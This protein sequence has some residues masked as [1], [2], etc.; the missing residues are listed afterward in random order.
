MGIIK[1]R[2]HRRGTSLVKS[3]YKTLSRMSQGN[4]F[5]LYKRED[6]LYKSIKKKFEIGR[7]L[8]PRR[9]TSV[10]LNSSIARK[11]DGLTR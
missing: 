7:S 4:S 1:V 9:R 11:M 2:A 6:T 10:F 8:S 3:Y 5:K